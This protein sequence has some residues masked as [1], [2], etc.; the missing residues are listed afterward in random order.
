[1]VHLGFSDS[2]GPGSFEFR[3]ASDPHAA[4]NGTVDVYGEVR[5]AGVENSQEQQQTAPVPEP[6]S[7]ILFG[8]GL[9]AAWRSRRKRLSGHGIR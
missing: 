2:G 5:H 9:A 4:K 7:L 8:S 6:A 1:V 3:I